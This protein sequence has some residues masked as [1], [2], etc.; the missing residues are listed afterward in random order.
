MSFKNSINGNTSYNTSHTDERT[1]LLG[2]SSK[3][4]SC[5]VSADKACPTCKGTGRVKKSLLNILFLFLHHIAFLW[6][7][8]YL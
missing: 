3:I 8:I 2:E 5:S 4:R 6:L 1:N 7:K